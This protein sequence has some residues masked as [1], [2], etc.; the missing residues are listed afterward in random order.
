MNNK[1]FDSGDGASRTDKYVYVC[2]R[3]QANQAD[4]ALNVSGMCFIHYFSHDS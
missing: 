1:S 2:E 3:E 4:Q